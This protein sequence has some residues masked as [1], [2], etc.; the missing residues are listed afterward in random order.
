MHGDS[1]CAAGGMNRQIGISDDISILNVIPVPILLCVSF[2]L[3][4]VT[5]LWDMII[6]LCMCKGQESHA[7]A[8]DFKSRWLTTNELDLIMPVTGKSDNYNQ[9]R[10]ATH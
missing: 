3:I 6:C 1:S 10:D 2:Y 7:N 5:K 8:I 9:I 4:S